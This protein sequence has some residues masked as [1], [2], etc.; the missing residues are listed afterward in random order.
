MKRVK[1]FA[2]VCSTAIVLYSC[3]KK[4]YPA[5]TP[6]TK[7]ETILTPETRADSAVV[8]KP[9]IKRKPKVPVAK[10]ITVNDNAAHKSVDGRLYYDV[11]GKRYWKNYVDGKYYLFNKSMYSDPA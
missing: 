3:H 11:S 2:L 10:V 6:E 4:N 8:K 9:A 1:L 5:K 7:T